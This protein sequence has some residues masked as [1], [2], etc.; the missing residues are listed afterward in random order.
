MIQVIGATW[1]GQSA[2]KRSF[3]MV[4]SSN[5]QVV[6]LPYRMGCIGTRSVFESMIT[7]VTLHSYFGAESVKKS[8][9]QKE[10]DPNFLPLELNRF[11]GQ[12]GLFHVVV[13][14]E[15]GSPSWNG[16]RAFGVRSLVTDP[17]IL[18]KYEHLVVIEDEEADRE[19]ECL[20]ASLEDLSQKVHEV[21]S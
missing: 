9:V 7:P 17:T 2:T 8:W 13:K 1:V 11:L 4:I 10:M 21:V 16:P 6:Q 15:V 18:S 3:R 14:S 12:K 20:W 5:V 19:S